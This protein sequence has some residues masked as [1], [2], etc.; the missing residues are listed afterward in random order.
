MEGGAKLF[1][2]AISNTY[3]RADTIEGMWVAASNDP[4]AVGGGDGLYL[5][6]GTD[7][8]ANLTTIAGATAAVAG[9]VRPLVFNAPLAGQ[10]S[11]ND[12]A[13]FHVGVMS[14]LGLVAAVATGPADAPNL[15]FGLRNPP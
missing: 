12:G 4:I 15:S 9:H 1:A 6:E 14:S 3:N 7:L 13:P 5:L 10:F 2:A 11:S 8:N